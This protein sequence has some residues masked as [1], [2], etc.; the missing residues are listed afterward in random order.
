[1][2]LVLTSGPCSLLRAAPASPEAVPASQ[3]TGGSPPF[4]LPQVQETPTR[5]AAPQLA[6]LTLEPPP[7]P[8]NAG[9][10][11]HRWN[12]GEGV[13]RWAARGLEVSALE[14]ERDALRGELAVAHAQ[15]EGLLSSQLTAE[16]PT[17]GGGEVAALEAELQVAESLPHISH[18][19]PTPSLLTR[20]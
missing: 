9:E 1:V 5:G 18:P 20:A 17:K 16:Q 19:T 7:Q 12:A 10:G 15:L 14:A 8:R 4:H 6:E 2:T 11:V 3:R 13:H